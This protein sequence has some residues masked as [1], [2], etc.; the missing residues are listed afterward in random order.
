M[1]GVGQGE[2]AEWWG[3]AVARGKAMEG[4]RELGK[5]SSFSFE[6]DGKPWEN[7]KMRN[8]M[9]YMFKHYNF[10]CST[11]NTLEGRRIKA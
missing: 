11:E 7:F 8:D 4:L 9:T 5:E 2:S 1:S 10:D 6:W 3:Q